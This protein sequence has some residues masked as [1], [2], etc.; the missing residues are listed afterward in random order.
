MKVKDRRVCL[1]NEWANAIGYNVGDGRFEIKERTYVVGAGH[2]DYCS[3]S[4]LDHY[5]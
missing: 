1:W 2:H 4:L 5:L 3:S